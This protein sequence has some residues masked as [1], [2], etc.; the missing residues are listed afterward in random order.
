[1]QTQTRMRSTTSDVSARPD[2]VWWQGGLMEIKARAE[3]TGGALGLVEGTFFYQ[4]YGPPLHVH[5]RED[6]AMYVLEG[7]I[8]IRVGDDE[9]VAGPG[10]WVWQPRGVPHTF[11]VESE[12]ARALFV[13]TPGGLESMFEEG[14]VPAGDSAEPPQQEYDPEAAAA[15]AQSYGFEVVGPLLA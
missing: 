8:R 7:A 5:S 3:D 6:E 4:G 12:G 9:L 2:T 10:T 11:K 15:L 13:F 1:M 14:G